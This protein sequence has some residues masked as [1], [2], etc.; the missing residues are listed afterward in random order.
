MLSEYKLLTSPGGNYVG[1]LYF[2]QEMNGWFPYSRDTDYLPEWMKEE[3][4]KD[5]IDYLNNQ[6]TDDESF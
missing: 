5:V 2:D 6:P 1:R 4:L 3:D